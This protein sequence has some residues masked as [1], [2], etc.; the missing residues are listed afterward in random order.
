[1]P[2]DLELPNGE[3]VEV[4]DNVEPKAALA[5]LK[6][7]KT[8]G[9]LFPN[10]KSGMYRAF[11]AGAVRGVGALDNALGHGLG[12]LL[13]RPD[14]TK[15]YLGRR[16]ELEAVA[17][18]QFQPTTDADVAQARAK[19]V[20][21]GAVAN[22][23]QEIGEPV[24]GVVGGM[25]PVLGAT[26][27]AGPVAGGLVAS[28][29]LT[30]ENIDRYTEQGKPVDV[31]RAFLLS[32]PQAAM[33]VFFAS[34]LLRGAGAMEKA[35]EAAARVAPRVAAGELTRDQAIKEVQSTA[36]NMLSEMG[37]TAATGIASENA[38]SVIGRAG[39]GQSL[40]D[41]DA[42][43]EYWA[44]TKTMGVLGGVA[45]GV[46]GARAKGSAVRNVI[47]PAVQA[48]NDQIITDNLAAQQQAE[49][50]AA[51]KMAA[52]P[53]LPLVSDAGPDRRT[54]S[55]YQG[56][57]FVGPDRRARGAPPVDRRDP[58]APQA[59]VD[60]VDRRFESDPLKQYHDTTP[61]TVE[62]PAEPGKRSVE[63]PE[64][65]VPFDP[66][67]STRNPSPF[68]DQQGPEGP[69]VG[70]DW[71]SNTPKPEVVN[72]PAAPQEPVVAAPAQPQTQPFELTPSPVET[73]VVQNRRASDAQAEPALTTSDMFAGMVR[74][75]SPTFKKLAGKDLSNPADVKEV[76]GL[77][78]KYRNN[79]EK[80]ADDTP[81]NQ[82]RLTDLDAAIEA[83]NGLHRQKQPELK[84]LKHGK[85][86][87][88]QPAAV[89][90][91]IDPVR[92]EQEPANDQDTNQS[93]RGGPDPLGNLPDMGVRDE[94]A[95]VAGAPAGIGNEG[96]GIPDGVAGADAGRTQQEPAALEEPAAND[97]PP[98]Q[99]AGTMA[100]LRPVR[101]ARQSKLEAALPHNGYFADNFREARRDIGNALD[102]RS[103]GDLANVLAESSNP[104]VQQIGTAAKD[105]R[106]VRVARHA[107]KNHY[108][109]SQQR[110]DIAQPNE[111]V[112]AHEVAHVLTHQALDAPTP[113]QKIHVKR[114]TELFE[115]VRAKMLKEQGIAPEQFAQQVKDKKVDTTPD[116]SSMLYAV[117][118]I[119]EFVAEGF[120][121]ADFQRYLANTKYQNKTAWSRF[122]E[123][124]ARLLGLQNDNALTE[125]LAAGT[126][127]I[128]ADRRANPVD[129]GVLQRMHDYPGTQPTE[130][131]RGFFESAVRGARD[132]A[133]TPRQALKGRMGEMLDAFEQGFFDANWGAMRHLPRKWTREIMGQKKATGLALME[134]SAYSAQIGETS[135][136]RGGVAMNAEGIFE[137]T[138]DAQNNMVELEKRVAQLGL[139]RVNGALQ[140]LAY[141]E[142]LDKLAAQKQ[143]AQTNINIA[144]AD[145]KAAASLPAKQ[146]YR[147][148]SKAK[149]VINEMQAVLDED[150]PQP[151]NV[152]AQSIA[153]ARADLASEPAFKEVVD[154]IKNINLQNIKTLEQGGIIT[155]ETAK[156]W[157][158]NEHYIPLWRVMDEDGTSPYASRSTMTVQTIRSFEGSERDVQDVLANL[159][160]QR[161][162]VT[163]A[164]MTNTAKLQTLKELEA[165]PTNSAGV[166]RLQSATKPQGVPNIVT[167]KED[168]V[169]VHYKV[170]DA[171]AFKTFQ[172]IVEGTPGTFMKA[173][174]KVTHL[175]RNSLI[176]S[177]TFIAKS[178][179][180]DNLDAWAYGQTNGSFARILAKSTSQL[181]R[182]LPNIARDMRRGQ[183]IH[184]HHAV[185][186]YGITGHREATTL[187]R[188]IDAIIRAGTSQT[189]ADNWA[190]KADTALRMA[191]KTWESVASEAE[192]AT[193]NQVFHD[194]FNRTGSV[195]EGAMAAMNTMNFRRRGSWQIITAAKMMVP[196]FN[197]NLQGI[198]KAYRAAARGDAMGM[199]SENARRLIAVQGFK[200]AVAA[201]VMAA[202]MADDEDYKDVPMSDRI[203]NII[204]PLGDGEHNIKLPLNFEL[205][206]VFWALPQR[207]IEYMNNDI[208]G[209]ELKEALQAMVLHNTPP[210]FPQVAKPIVE[211]VTNYSMFR[212]GPLES[213]AQQRIEPGQ[214]VN[215]STSGV[216]EAIGGATNM[217][218][219]KIQNV[220]E[221]Y[222][223]TLGGFALDMTDKLLGLDANK[224]ASAGN[225]LPFISSFV[226]DPNRSN[227]RNN[228]YD[229]KEFSDEVYSTANKLEAEGDLDRL[230][231]Y[232]DKK[233]PAGITNRQLYEYREDVNAVAKVFADLNKEERAVKASNLPPQQKRQEIDA[234]RQKGKEFAKEIEP[235]M[236]AAFA[237]E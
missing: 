61:R 205:G 196:F 217:S 33:D 235:R 147:I 126:N 91:S 43:E 55:P 107:R 163:D 32:L 187:R 98:T 203:A 23:R 41:A 11:K 236:K 138:E 134:M 158:A 148:I 39:T 201:S 94:Q 233:S 31:N 9:H 222:F 133:N 105:V 197:S 207:L 19:G 111:L 12:K 1:M 123:S 159:T 106:G 230:H 213:A 226:V 160:R 7:S 45:G 81:E 59:F 223:G 6:A 18:D 125:F 208:D 179:F 117:S 131:K 212:K 152:N 206:T 186:K 14:V 66:A 47:D 135:L 82:Q 132:V 199:K 209:R 56:D 137:V 20:I 62:L 225:R 64:G 102:A 221:G 215:D 13:G 156:M 26:A 51:A 25:V 118:D 219:I 180:R 150:I 93:V 73:P 78:K 104:I 194:A 173:I 122:V 214:R 183:P 191:W 232:L 129:S 68:L 67:A 189:M 86:A 190:A 178:L 36:R 228:I 168:G 108:V 171:L 113:T 175:F 157:R 54:P 15:R 227:A 4:P 144:R 182:E 88:D 143:Q 100:A 140:N 75:Q 172:G 65:F 83:L 16:A 216:A 146:G 99:P 79:V 124:V 27:A 72:T 24:A 166:T 53:Q 69:T 70:Y 224:P 87:I 60:G 44:N 48:R 8:Y 155:P 114:M 119:H 141:A 120:G 167:V 50:D 169:N 195:T 3:V 177:P 162:M 49:Q 84:G 149:H 10:E 109:P 234:L 170:D 204:L 145:I 128:E 211:N 151:A 229:L 136:S 153:D 142:R 115:F 121:N 40:T 21:P 174:E 200:M 17:A 34:K 58:N 165:L 237:G 139:E 42:R 22:L 193:R 2:Y 5:K 92:V 181:A 101:D 35:R 164:A 192:V 116:N 89:V 184:R 95:A 130:P 218:P 28:G 176:L 76:A 80:V 29:Q 112:A 71:D 188:E 202:F 154:I 30:S 110:I 90:G 220:L 57:Q 85:A 231:D 38:Q 63:P 77:L 97:V 46:H 210:Y 96:R 52:E 185:T 127:L 161:L 198:Y 37:K 103:F 74:P